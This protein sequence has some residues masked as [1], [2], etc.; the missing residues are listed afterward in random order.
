MT[1]EPTLDEVGRRYPE[2]HCWRGVDR[3]YYA[4]LRGTDPPV[5]VRGEDPLDLQDMIQG[6]IYR[7]VR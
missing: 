3:L 2:W 4:R 6:A 5:L 7:A 1:A